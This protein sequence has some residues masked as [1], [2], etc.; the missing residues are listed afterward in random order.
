[1]IQKTQFW[2]RPNPSNHNFGIPGSPITLRDSGAPRPVPDILASM[3]EKLL[4]RPPPVRM[5]EALRWLLA[6]AFGPPDAS[7]AFLK[8]EDVL[9]VF[10]DGARLDLLARI[11]SRTKP[12]ILR[13]EIG[14]EGLT[15][16]QEWFE[17]TAVQVASL[18]K[19]LRNVAGTAL[20]LGIPLVVL[21]GMALD[22]SGTA[23]PGSRPMSDVDILVPDEHTVTLFEAL[24]RDGFVCP[25]EPSQRTPQHLPPLCDP[26]GF[27]LEI[28]YRIGHL[29]CGG[30]GDLNFSFLHSRELLRQAAGWPESVFLPSEDLLVAH[31]L[32][33][34]LSTHVGSFTSYA[35]AR[36]ICDLA[37]FPWD[38]TR[39]KSFFDGPYEWIRHAVSRGEIDVVR[40]LIDR[41][42]SGAD[43]LDLFE[44]KDNVAA[45]LGH[46][47]AICHW[48]GYQMRFFLHR[49]FRSD[50]RSLLLPRLPSDMSLSERISWHILRPFRVVPKLIVFSASQLH[51]RIRA[52][53]P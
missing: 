16:L 49:R 26:H 8:P 2:N 19:M 35:P 24:K 43:P 25:H 20:D 5:T 42:G 30:D 23:R 52:S 14:V 3:R 22:I 28:H 6:R 41:L 36:I 47:T 27:P 15:R 34:G 12:E 10:E 39:W 9:A 38:T 18:R 45:L 11:A 4:F 44:R 48:P 32:V 17:A 21:K 29:E 13:T 50:L 46:L 37:D 1:M 7:S 53:K 33:H 51:A 31:L 40:N